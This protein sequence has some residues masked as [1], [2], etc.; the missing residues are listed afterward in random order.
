MKV[1]AIIM[2]IYGMSDRAILREIG[3]RLKR[4]RLEKNLSQQRVAELAGLNRTT[5]RDIERGTPFGALTLVQVLRALG[6]LEELNSFLP[7]PGISPLQLAKM[8]GK[9]RR[10]ASP[11][12][13]DHDEGESDW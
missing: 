6:A 7:D 4:K 5:I 1:G 9:E 13:A 2:N 3:R 8:K 12:T 10:R 11:Q